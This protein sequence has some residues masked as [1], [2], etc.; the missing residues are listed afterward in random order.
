VTGDDAADDG[1]DE[2]GGQPEL[3][4]HAET[5]DG[6]VDVSV[7]GSADERAADLREPFNHALDRALDAC[8]DLPEDGSDD[9]HI[10]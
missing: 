5:R 1:A 10:H 6:A 8:D 7:T 9:S 2:A 3:S 4:V